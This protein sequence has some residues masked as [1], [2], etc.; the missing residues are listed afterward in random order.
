MYNGTPDTFT[1]GTPYEPFHKRKF[2]DKIRSILNMDQQI[3]D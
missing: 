3:I 1:G 2:R